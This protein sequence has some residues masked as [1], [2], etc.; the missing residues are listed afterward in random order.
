M[1]F[2]WP[3][4]CLHNWVIFTMSDR[5]NFDNIQSRVGRTIVSREFRHSMSCMGVNIFLNRFIWKDFPFND[6]LRT[7]DPN[8]IY[9][10]R[11]NQLNR[12]ISKRTCNPKFIVTKW[13]R[14]WFKCRPN[15]DS[16]VKTNIDC[17]WH[18]F[19]KFLIF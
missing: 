2:R 6:K 1:F 7:C 5:F 16:R 9:S 13:C 15:Q 14:W 4:R 8:F 18:W 11:I 19:V 17:N 3:N 12:L 10:N